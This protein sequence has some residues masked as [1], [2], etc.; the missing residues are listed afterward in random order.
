MNSLRHSSVDVWRVRLPAVCESEI[1]V[2][3]LRQERAIRK[4]TK[5]QYPWEINRT[6]RTSSAT[7]C[8][9]VGGTKSFEAVAKDAVTKADN[10]ILKKVPN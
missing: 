7:T 6:K 10:A 9:I 3:E 4:E 8:T 1:V 2:A 5:Q